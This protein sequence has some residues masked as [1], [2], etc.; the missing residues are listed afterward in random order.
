MAKKQKAERNRPKDTRDYTRHYNAVK[1]FAG[2]QAPFLAGTIKS[3]S[4]S[5]SDINKWVKTSTPFRK[6]AGVTPD[7]K[8]LVNIA[9]GM[10]KATIQDFKEGNLI[11]FTNLNNKISDLMG[12]MGEHDF[13]DTYDAEYD[14]YEEPSD[15]SGGGFD[16]DLYM[17]G[18]A[19][20]AQVT[21][22]AVSNATD[23]ISNAQI[24]ASDYGASKVISGTNVAI[25]RVLK[26]QATQLGLVNTLNNNMQSLVEM[27][28]RQESYQREA[29]QFFQ[30]TEDNLNDIIEIMREQAD[31]AEARR[32]SKYSYSRRGDEYNFLENGFDIKKYAKSIWNNSMLGFGAKEKLAELAP[33]LA[34]FGFDVS[35]LTEGAMSGMSGGWDG[36]KPLVQAF[37]LTPM[38]KQLSSLN[39]SAE[40]LTKIFFHKLSSGEVKTGITNVDDILTEAARY[41]LFGNQ[42]LGK[43]GYVSLSNYD[44]GV[45]KIT[46][47]TL[48]AIE[49]VIPTYLSNIENDI[50]TLV[51]GFSTGQ[52]EIGT[53]KSTT[54]KTDEERAADKAYFQEMRSRKHVNV[55]DYEDGKFV[56]ASVIATELQENINNL[57]ESSMRPM[58][59][60]ISSILDQQIVT[61]NE[62][63]KINDTLSAMLVTY[64][65]MKTIP[66]GKDFRDSFLNQI[67]S[68]GIDKSKFANNTAM[69][70][71]IDSLYDEMLLAIDRFQKD[72]ARF[73][74]SISNG[75]ASIYE[76]VFNKSNDEWKD[77][78][79][80][81]Q[82]KDVGK[83]L[84]VDTRN[85]KGSFEDG[86]GSKSHNFK[87][88]VNAEFDRTQRSILR[89]GVD[90]DELKEDMDRLRNAY[91]SYKSASPDNLKKA[92]W[93][94]KYFWKENCSS[95]NEYPSKYS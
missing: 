81:S 5:M 38:A 21:V 95:W 90:E 32:N 80:Y 77:D 19:I 50:A 94:C 23:I 65:N 31:P 26:Y 3:F 9:N 11:T 30:R 27:A 51:E 8:K 58:T 36:F 16:S 79:K 39:K 83:N 84:V 54:N 56:D 48:K 44:K 42:T 41:G 15:Y 2:E 47:K 1:E 37:N 91:Q 12:G 73:F 88:D 82:K 89:N 61:Q 76:N 70:N 75:E 85:L 67:E 55:Y 49:M 25:S 66:S 60:K 10:F 24:K 59:D 46:G 74:D 18:T 64:G 92:R 93:I 14:D 4:Q 33:Y 22:D 35:A 71:A 68:V 6:N 45:Q 62:W 78:L 87:R 34:L 28:S 40:D 13:D 29:L 52:F 53:F 7:E 72:K 20:S 17:Q 57:F 69:M 43:S 63:D 86:F